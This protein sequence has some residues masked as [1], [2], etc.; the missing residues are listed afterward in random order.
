MTN[1]GYIHRVVIHEEGFGARAG[2]DTTN[3]VES[4][5][6]E[7]KRL[8]HY[9]NGIHGGTKEPWVRVQHH[10]DA[11]FWRRRRRRIRQARFDKL[12]TLHEY[13]GFK[14][15]P[16]LDADGDPASFN[17][18]CR[19]RARILKNSAETVKRWCLDFEED[20]SVLIKLQ[21]H[22]TG[23]KRAK[24][25]GQI[26][27]RLGRLTCSRDIDPEL[28]DWVLCLIDMGV[29]LTRTDIK[30]KAI[31]FIEPNFKGT[32]GLLDAF[33]ERHHLSLRKPNSRASVQDEYADIALK[34]QRSIGEMIR[35]YHIEPKFIINLDEM[36][37][38]WEYL[39]RKMGKIYFHSETL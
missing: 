32:D 19:D 16:P 11:G 39:P 9:D 15:S 20:P 30:N 6:S 24:Q 18:F 10:I 35:K 23:A 1:I 4:L 38:F 36:A 26:N 8:T 34:F 3:N 25:T 29:A 28:Y 7:L 12:K 27:K 14:Q 21:T 5:W 37:I 22:C 31:E 33:L 13:I 17:Q 2:A